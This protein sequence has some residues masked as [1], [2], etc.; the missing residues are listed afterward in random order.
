VIVHFAD[1]RLE[2]LY[3]AGEGAEKYPES[4]VTA[5]LRRVRAIEAAVD[6]RDLREQKSFHFESLRG[7]AYSGKHSVRLNDKWRLILGIAGSGNR[8][9]VTVEE[10]TNHY[11][12]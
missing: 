5:F 3:A 2:R 10:I 1:G 11:G 4:V 7:K 8:K 12:D 9:T 6:E